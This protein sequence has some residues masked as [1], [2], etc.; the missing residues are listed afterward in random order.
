MCVF[1]SQYGRR[2]QSG[3]LYRGNRNPCQVPGKTSALIRSTN[4]CNFDGFIRKLNSEL[5]L[6]PTCRKAYFL[7]PPITAHSVGQE[8]FR[9]SIFKNPEKSTKYLKTFA[10]CRLR[11]ILQATESSQNIAPQTGPQKQ[12]SCGEF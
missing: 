1:P 7:Q 5:S 3:P 11:T 6:N 9:S 2:P 12:L 8:T 10:K 4:E